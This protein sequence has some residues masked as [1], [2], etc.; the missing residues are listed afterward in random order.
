M[1]TAYSGLS[2][3]AYACFST[4]STREVKLAESPK[5][6]IVVDGHCLRHRDWLK[7]WRTHNV[8]SIAGKEEVNQLEGCQYLPRKWKHPQT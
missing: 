7:G 5:I 4:I 8:G 2:G 3:K 1:S 6:G